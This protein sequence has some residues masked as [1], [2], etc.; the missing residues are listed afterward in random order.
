MLMVT[1]ILVCSMGVISVSA[2]YDIDVD[3][4]GEINVVVMGG[5]EVNHYTNDATTNPWYR[6][7][8]GLISAYTGTEGNVLYGK[9]ANLYTVGTETDTSFEGAMVRVD[10]ALALNPDL[11]I[12]NYSS[13]F[14]Y[15]GTFKDNPTTSINN[16]LLDSTAYIEKIVARFAEQE[17]VPYVWQISLPNK[18]TGYNRNL[19][20]YAVSRWGIKTSTFISSAGA[21]QEL[22]NQNLADAACWDEDGNLSWEGHKRIGNALQA[23]F[24][25]IWLN[26]TSLTKPVMAENGPYKSGNTPVYGAFKA[27]TAAV[28]SEGF[29]AQSDGSMVSSDAGDTLTITLTG[30]TFGVVHD[31]AGADYEIKIGGARFVSID[32]SSIPVYCKTGYGNISYKV[33]IQASD[34]GVKIKGFYE[35][36]IAITEGASA[37]GKVTAKMLN[38]SLAGDETIPCVMVAFYDNNNKFIGISTPDW[39]GSVNSFSVEENALPG[40]AKAKVVVWKSL[41][42]L[43]PLCNATD[44]ITLN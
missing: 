26:G 10:E 29:V 23:E 11:V 25:S 9:T 17:N 28:A 3:N 13:D 38:S 18:N 21:V 36:P 30:R 6:R 41:E 20:A 12:L 16:S 1:F 34:A 32:S 35:S 4:N 14:R 44:F 7:F 2:A 37:D 39:N 31:L 22:Q 42:S 15:D 40:A 8:F 27:A 24:K 43:K 33:T 19:Q 5:Y